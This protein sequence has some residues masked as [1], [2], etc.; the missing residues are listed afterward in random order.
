MNTLYVMIGLPG[1]GKSTWIKN[2]CGENSIIIS[3]DDL[4]E[5]IFKDVNNQ[6]NNAKVFTT[7][8]ELTF[9]ALTNNKSVYYDATNVTRKNRQSILDFIKSNHIEC[10]KVA[11]IV[12]TPYEEC[13]RRNSIRNRHV[14]EHV[15]KNMMERFE[16]PLIN[17]GFDEILEIKSVEPTKLWTDAYN[18]MKNFEQKN[19]NHTLTLDKHCEK[20]FEYILNHEFNRELQ[21]AAYIHDYGKLFTQTY[22]EEKHLCHYINHQN[23]GAYESLTFKYEDNINPYKVALYINYHMEPFNLKNAKYKEDF[24]PIEDCDCYACKSYTKAY[25]RHLIV[26][27]ETFGARLLSIHNIRYLIHLTEELREAIKEDRLLAYREQFIKDYYGE[28]GLP[29]QEEKIVKY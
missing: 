23:V 7:M 26:A 2:H 18:E 17:E 6:E 24:T 5:K 11:V 15:I 19:P 9:E 13:L 1:S 16:L 25:I 14:P 4:R 12:E 20:V 22:D 27:D 10:R 21:I 29:Y 8:R 3:S 28:K